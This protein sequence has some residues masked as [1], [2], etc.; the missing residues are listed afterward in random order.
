ME[1][2][3]GTWVVVP[4]FN[5]EHSL[6]AVLTG[7]VGRGAEVV[8]VDD[9][10]SDATA[11]VAL[12]FPVTLLRH[13][14]NLGQGAALQTGLRY[15]LA[16][17]ETRYIVTF[18]ADGQHSADDIAPLLAPL[19]AGTHDVALGSR[20]V[21]GGR[22]VNISPQKRL[23]LRLALG[24]TR[25]TTGLHLTDTHNGLRALTVA[26]AARLTITQNRMAHA[27][28]ILEQVA[29]ARLR[30]C[31]VP[32]TVRYTPYSLAKGQGVLESIN[33]LWEMIFGRIE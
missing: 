24:F 18:D 31:E 12:T 7:L 32:V 29:R 20:F 3:A 22:A 11:Q 16:M 5:E 6:A 2:P 28:E 17:A 19:A 23:L 8:V 1:I 15:A 26:A 27:S 9:G 30:V 13:A 4:T 25:A 10:S 21:A 33:V 14:S